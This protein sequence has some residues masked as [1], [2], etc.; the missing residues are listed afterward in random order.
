MFAVLKLCT[1]FATVRRVHQRPHTGFSAPRTI[2]RQG[3]FFLAAACLAA[4][5]YGS[6]VP[7]QYNGRSFEDAVYA[8]LHIPYLSLG[9]VSRADWVANIILYIPMG[10]LWTGAFRPRRWAILA[11]VSCLLSFGICAGAAVF[12]EFTQLFFSPRTVSINDLLAEALGSLIGIGIWTVFGNMLLRFWEDITHGTARAVR[13]L[14][15]VYLILYIFLG[16]FPYDFLISGA[17]LRWKL[18]Q[19]KEGAVFTTCGNGGLRCLAKLAAEI[20]AMAPLGFFLC[21]GSEQ[22]KS[23][24]KAVYRKAFFLGAAI[25]AGIET[26][27]FFMVS[28]ISRAVS[29]F[30]RASGAAAGVGLYRLFQVIQQDGAGSRMLKWAVLFSAPPYF[31]AMTVLNRWFDG[32]PIGFNAA[33]RR[34]SRQQFIPFYYHYYSSEPVAMTSLLSHAALYAPMGLGLWV[35]ARDKTRNAGSG[36]S[37]LPPAVLGAAAAAV[38]E[39]GRLCMS[40]L[41]PDPTNIL[42]AAASAALTYKT[43]VLVGRW[44]AADGFRG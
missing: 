32:S 8:F 34:L 23:E 30:A 42:I 20:L 26:V 4:V 14:F 37:I 21:M 22:G 43:A 11:P 2:D 27:Q 17:E 24:R 16:L 3:L 35:L 40:G 1:K 41:H 10:F 38:M 5:A 7:F 33:I 25:G 19:L 28:G 29:V 31:I 6:L 12:I 13:S 39:F 15:T 9:A 18:A 36:Y 44:A